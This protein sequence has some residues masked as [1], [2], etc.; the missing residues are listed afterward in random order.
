[1]GRRVRPS[2]QRRRRGRPAPARQGRSAVRH[3]V[4]PDRPRRGLPTV[5]ARRALSR[6]PIRAKLTLA[7][8]GVIALMLAAIGVFLYAHFE[9]GLDNA[10][11][12]TLRAR[13]DDVGA[14]LRQ[15]GGRGLQRQQ[16]LL[17]GGDLTAQL[18]SPI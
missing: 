5:P 13:A 7:Y 3:R 12:D 6:L 2:I 14:L 11:D 9:S 17:A 16:S 8:S 18:L 15:D 1:M 10:L 4:D